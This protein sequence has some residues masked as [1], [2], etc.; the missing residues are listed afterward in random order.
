MVYQTM[1]EYM[2]VPLFD[3]PRDAQMVSLY[4]FSA[5]AS[6]TYLLAINRCIAERSLNPQLYCVGG[7]V[8]CL[9]EPLLTR[10]LDATHAQN[11]RQIAYESL[12]QLVPWHAAIS[13]TLYLGLAYLSLVPALRERRYAAATIGLI[14]PGMTL[15][16]WIYEV[17][18]I[19]VGLWSYFGD[20]LFQPL[21]LQPVYWSFASM[22]MLITPTALIARYEALLHGWRK[23]LIAALA[24]I[25]ALRAQPVP[26]GPSGLR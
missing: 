6:L 11:G 8:T 22:A 9:L 5:L 15:S 10:L 21:G 16:A 2:R 4:V 13:C 17:P 3:M 23:I 26:A 24:P 12:G 20:Q 19:R 7:N 25:G 1:P 14:L 18:L